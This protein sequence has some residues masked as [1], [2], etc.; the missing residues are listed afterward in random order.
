[1]KAKQCRQKP[2]YVIIYTL[3]DYIYII[4]NIVTEHILHL[5]FVRYRINEQ[6]SVFNKN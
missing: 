4:F 3:F 5:R 2:V 6:R 1:M